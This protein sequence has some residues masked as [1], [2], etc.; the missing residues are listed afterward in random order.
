M[1]FNLFQNDAVAKLNKISVSKK[2]F[3]FNDQK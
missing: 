3:Q 2:F 1:S